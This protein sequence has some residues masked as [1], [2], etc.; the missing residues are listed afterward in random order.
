MKKLT[1][2]DFVRLGIKIA[3]LTGISPY[4]LPKIVNALE[5][6]AGKNAPVLWLQGQSCSG[7]SVSRLNSAAPGPAE[8]LT[9]SG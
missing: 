2:R 7:C 8:I 5:E 3:A 6:L 4:A 1:R 9:E